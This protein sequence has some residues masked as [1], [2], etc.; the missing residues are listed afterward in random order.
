MEAFLD[1]KYETDE[2]SYRKAPGDCN[3]Y[4]TGRIGRHSVVLVY[5]P[6]MGKVNA[7]ATA[8]GLRSSFQNI[9]LALLVGICGGVPVTAD[10]TEVLLGDVIFTT[11]IIQID[12][13]RQ[14][15]DRFIRR[16]STEASSSRLG[17]EIRAFLQKISGSHVQ[18]LQDRT[19]SYLVE[20]QRHTSS[21]LDYPGLEKDVLF[22]AHYQHKHQIANSTIACDVCAESDD[23]ICHSALS[24][25]CKDLGCD[26]SLLLTR[27][28]VSDPWRPFIHFGGIASADVVM[29]SGMHRDEIARREN[30]T[31]F[32][33]EGAGMWDYLPTIVIKSV[34]DYADSHKNKVWQNYSAYVAAA[35]AKAVLADWRIE[36]M[37]FESL[38]SCGELWCM[39]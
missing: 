32:E 8:A 38:E 27:G 2:F 20:K 21:F 7:A 23:Q 33:M 4:T 17:P 16:D 34:C 13:G 31:A 14:Y 26:E 22:P 18:V 12:F 9:K 24:A 30:I 28:R 5:M 19:S 6:G 10:K 15:P 25:S 3:A 29:K 39:V 35:C 1:E 37:A 36:N 11:N